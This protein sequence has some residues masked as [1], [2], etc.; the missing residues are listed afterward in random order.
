MRSTR[1]TTHNPLR[2]K[3][4]AFEE[5]VLLERFHAVLRA[6]GLEAASGRKQGRNNQ[7][8]TTNKKNSQL[9]WYFLEYCHYAL[10][11]IVYIP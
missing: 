4:K 3:Q 2:G 11:T 8:I 5:T 7:L 6:R 1:S 10:H 9:S